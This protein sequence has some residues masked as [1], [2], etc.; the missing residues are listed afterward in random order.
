MIASD[1]PALKREILD[2]YM[3][4]RKAIPEIMKEECCIC[5]NAYI[6]DEL[7]RESICHHIFHD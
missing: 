5:L 4:V 1:V 6:K 3:P 7:V 2:E